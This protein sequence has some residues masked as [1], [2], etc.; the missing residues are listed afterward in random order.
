MRELIEGPLTQRDIDMKL[1]ELF[2]DSEQGWKWEA[3]SFELPVSIKDR[4][5]A[6]PR[7]L[8]GRGEDVIMWKHSKDGE[9]TTN[10]A[11]AWLNGSQQEEVK[12]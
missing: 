8:V 3:L 7:Q 11:Y 1:S 10:S 5:K 2:L 12:F 4:I 9:F 6:V